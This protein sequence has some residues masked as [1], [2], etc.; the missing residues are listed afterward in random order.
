M[1]GVFCLEVQ[2]RKNE[3]GRGVTFSADRN[4]SPMSMKVSDNIT[5]APFSTLTS[6][7]NPCIQALLTLRR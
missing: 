1:Q 5:T 7:N 4:G 2:V 6:R 3:I